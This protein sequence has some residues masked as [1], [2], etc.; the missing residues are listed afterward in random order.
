[1][2]DKYS[3]IKE[4]KKQS[5]KIRK[6]WDNLELRKRQSETVK[7]IWN[8]RKADNISFNK[9]ECI[10]ILD[11]LYIEFE[12]V[13][14]LKKFIKDTYHVEFGN[15]VLHDML[16]SESPYSPFHKNNKKLQKLSGMILKF[17]ILKDEITFNSK[18]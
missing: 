18:S 4:R 10:F 15:S 16:K 2:K 6:S 8:K 11:D 5:D 9:K 3:D 13:K 1:M 12:S 17:N 14:K 7:S